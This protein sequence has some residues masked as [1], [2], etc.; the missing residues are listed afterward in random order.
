[1]IKKFHDP[2]VYIFAVLLI[3]SLV[4]LAFIPINNVQEGKLETVSA[5]VKD[6][7]SDLDEVEYALSEN[8]RI[9]NDDYSSNI[10]LDTESLQEN[11]DEV[12]SNIQLVEEKIK[13]AQERPY[14]T[15]DATEEEILVDIYNIGRP[16]RI[17]NFEN[18]GMEL[19]VV[20]RQ[21]GMFR[22]NHS[23][24]DYSYDMYLMG[25]V[26]LEI[27]ETDGYYLGTT[28]LDISNQDSYPINYA[29]LKRIGTEEEY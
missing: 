28:A 10:S 24:G 12:N 26:A 16:N 17:Q 3:F 20:D 2:F 1:M 23:N 15:R 14:L 25:D 27:G 6:V 18:E 5:D 4:N 29:R 7:Q 19:E 9:I 21:S 8:E 22:I 11:I 13:V